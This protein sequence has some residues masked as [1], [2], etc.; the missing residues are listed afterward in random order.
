MIDWMRDRAIGATIFFSFFLLIFIVGIYG[1]FNP[2]KKETITLH[3]IEKV[4]RACAAL[5]GKE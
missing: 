5:E 3:D 4:R 2:P 1:L